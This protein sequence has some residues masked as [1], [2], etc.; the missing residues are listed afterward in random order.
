MFKKIIILL[1]PLILLVS[2]G[3]SK[4]EKKADQELESL[5]DNPVERKPTSEVSFENDK[6]NWGP[7]FDWPV[8]KARLTRGFLPRRGRSHWGIDLA[9]PK[10]TPI[11]SSQKGMVIYAG[12][13][14]RGFGKMI[15]IEGGEGWATLYAHLDRIMVN[16]G[17]KIQQGDV[18]GLMGRTGRASGN[19]LHF[20]I[21]RN[22][23]PV[24][25]LLYLPRGK[26]AA[27][28]ISKN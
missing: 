8:D 24:D 13:E 27:R 20:E 11:L 14:F 4:K 25:P 3:H 10:G 22:K 17:Q 5:Y 18:I 23:G 15:L 21:R 1:S 16:E 28:L 6:K 7:T 26:E 2:C 9:G 19:H 12:R